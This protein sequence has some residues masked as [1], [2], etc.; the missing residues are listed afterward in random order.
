MPRSPTN[1]TPPQAPSASWP[2]N[3]YLL[4]GLTYGIATAAEGD[5]DPGDSE[6]AAHDRIQWLRKTRAYSADAYQQLA[7]SYALGGDQRSAD[8]VAVESQRD[9]RKRG[10]L[11]RRSRIWNRFVDISVGYGYRLHRP[12][13]ALLILGLA[14]TLFYYLAEG[15]RL[16][17]STSGG[18]TAPACKPGY[19]CFNAFMY[20]FQLLIPGLDLREATYWLPNGDAYP[21]GLVMMLYTWF[22]IGFGWIAATAVVAGVSRIFRQR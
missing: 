16:I 2:P 10:N 22:M 5:L 20:S 14:G 18:L 15:A 17:Y 11:Q 8:L 13:L 7:R 12:F 3:N 9:L 19:P 6:L 21:W 4:A 1:S